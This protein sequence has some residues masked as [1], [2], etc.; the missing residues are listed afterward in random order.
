MLRPTKE[1]K[2]NKTPQHANRSLREIGIGIH[3]HLKIFKLILSTTLSIISLFLLMNTV[4]PLSAMGS[5]L[6]VNST[7]DVDDADPGDGIC[8]SDLTLT[9][10]QCTLR[11]SISEANASGGEYTI[12]I[13]AGTY[14]LTQ[15]GILEDNNQT[16]D[17]DIRSNIA[18]IGAGAEQTII[19]AGSTLSDSV[20]RVFHIAQGTLQVSFTGLTIQHG[21]IA[22]TETT[23]GQID[24][25]AGI[26]ILANSNSVVTI[27][28][29][30]ITQNHNDDLREDGGGIANMG[31]ATVMITDSE[32]S[33]N[34]T[35]RE[36]GSSG[37][38]L[39]S[40][41]GSHMIIDNSV[42]S[43]NIAGGKGGGIYV[44][45]SGASI[46]LNNSLVFNNHA[47]DIGGGI[48]SGS[49]V[50]ITNSTIIS[51][52]TYLSGAGISN[53][54]SASELYLLNVTISENVADSDSTGDAGGGVHLI[55][56]RVY[57]TNTI[58]A[59]NYLGNGTADDCHNDY[60]FSASY[61]L[62]ETITNC[63]LAGTHNITSTDPLLQPLADYG[64]DSWS[65]MLDVN[66]PAKNSGS[67]IDC[68]TKDQRNSIRPQNGACD[69][70]AIEYTHVAI[71]YTETSID[72]DHTFYECFNI[73]K[74]DTPY[75][76]FNY[77]ETT[78]TAT[79]TLTEDAYYLFYGTVNGVEAEQ[80]AQIG[81]FTYLLQT[82]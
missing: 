4:I 39:F 81:H 49:F 62:I 18:L 1:D 74:S 67:L 29:C 20:D 42:I 22:N 41:F 15:T 35:R 6:V 58:I 25:G 3:M 19:Q 48:Q 52:S 79:T 31:G 9:G 14:T 33:N 50:A 10:D 78:C 27:A 69:I 46:R 54:S 11:A 51:N 47:D 40:V 23:S 30:K 82:P 17:L 64:G 37:G 59:N 80:S 43:G 57:L 71:T 66:S 36:A 76:G 65:V 70:G 32:I 12:T 34:S 55:N 53:D 5:I 72:L 68:P 60:P 45:V 21:Y 73:W 38:G 61:S 75:Q 63:P 44:N 77:V 8:D 7:A 16:G 26:F 56:G 13:P 2:I 24:D 28:H